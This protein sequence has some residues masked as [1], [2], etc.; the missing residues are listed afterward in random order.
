MS[1]R[2]LTILLV[3]VNTTHAQRVFTLKQAVDT[4]MKNNLELKQMQLEMESAGIDWRQ[5]KAN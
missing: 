5:S 3:V 1:L 2:I 4:A